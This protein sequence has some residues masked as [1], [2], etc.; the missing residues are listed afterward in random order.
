MRKCS[1]TKKC[2][3]LTDAANHNSNTFPTQDSATAII[4]NNNFPFSDNQDS[5]ILEEDDTTE[6]DNENDDS[7]I[8]PAP[9]TQELNL[10]P[11]GQ[12]YKLSFY[13]ENEKQTTQHTTENGNHDI[14][15]HGNYDGLI[16]QSYDNTAESSRNVR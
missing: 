4:L 1:C 12:P 8:I 2:Y 16:V 13:Y 3:W 10:Q 15:H 11:T 5:I 14:G 6:Y 9:I 7:V